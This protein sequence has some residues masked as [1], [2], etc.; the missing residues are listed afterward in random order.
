MSKQSVFGIDASTQSMT[1]LLMEAGSGHVLWQKSLAYRDDPRLLGYGFEHDSLLIPPRETGEAEQPPRLFIAALEALLADLQA[2]GADM[3]A[4]AAINVSGQQH[5]HVYL[6][7]AAQA[8]FAGLR[9]AGRSKTSLV[10]S[11][12]GSFA[13]GGA[14]IWKTANTVAEAEHIRKQAGGRAAVIAASGSDIPLRFSACA[15][16]KLSIRYPE[17]WAATRHILQISALVPAILAGDCAIGADFGNACGT[18]L[19]NY[20]K[21]QWDPKL[22][23]AACGDRP[24]GA[25]ALAGKLPKLVHPLSP[26]GTVA[27]WFQERFGLSAACQVL[28]GSGDN[29]QSKVL[30]EG[31]LLSLGT[32]FVCMVDSPDGAVDASGAANAMYDGLGRPFNFVCRT[33]G[34]LAW[35]RLR[36]RHGIALKDYASGEQALASQA[37]GTLLRFWH[38]DAESFPLIGARP[39]LDKLDDGPDGFAAD[40]SGVVDTTLGLMYQY[41]RQM[42]AGSGSKADSG[43]LAVCGGPSASPGMMKRIAAI[44]NRPAIQA[45]QA[46][47]ALGAAVAAAVALAPESQR[48]DRAKQLRASI[49]EGK[50]VFMPEPALVAAYHGKGAQGS[51]LERLEKGFEKLRREKA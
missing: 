9:Q 34:A 46:G 32:S 39:D 30:A 49:F 47:A 14:P 35:D 42:A 13:Y 4:I 23:E 1:G 43:A 10:D 21:R 40:W 11:L 6:G 45:G 19:M 24:G 22:L 25:A 51:W 36:T 7:Q 5:G 28:A 17:A 44:W 12:A 2:S 16:R 15:H 37:P 31:D 27:A 48:L 50:T 41:S 33:N 26:V 20:A 38:P 3:A 29:P 8:S 18:G